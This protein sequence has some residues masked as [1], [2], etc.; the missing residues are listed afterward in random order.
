MK[1]II[2]LSVSV[3][4]EWKLIIKE[5]KK[6]KDITDDLEIYSEDFDEE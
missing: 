6:I 2:I 5:E 1:V 3:L 4:K